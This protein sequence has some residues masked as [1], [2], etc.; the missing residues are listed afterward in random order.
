LAGTNITQTF[1]NP[2]TVAIASV[3]NQMTLS[4]T[5]ATGAY[6]PACLVLA[7]SDTV[8][9]TVY[10]AARLC[11]GYE[12]ASFTNEKFA[13]QTAT[14]SGT[15][16]DVITAKNQVV[17]FAGDLVATA[18]TFSLTGGTMS[19][20]M[21]PLFNSTGKIG[22]TSY[23]YAN[24]YFTT[25]D[26]G[27]VEAATAYKMGGTTVINSS[28]NVVGVNTFAQSIIFSSG[29]TYNV[30]STGA[31]PLNVYGNYIE[32]LTELVLGSG[33]SFRGSLI[34]AINN[35]YAV[36]NTSFRVSNIATVNANISGT[37]TAPSG[38]TG[39]S[40]T[41]TVRDSAGTG[42]CTLIFSGGILTGGTC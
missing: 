31:P 35:T 16:Q 25:A 30:G 21:K 38:G 39:V 19:G 2:Q 8:G 10:G 13:I 1:V 7:S 14:G 3:Q 28:R 37:I 26:I 34:P 23:Y 12:T 32:P 27:T 17:T 40:A 6:D 15:Y 5:N 22:D 42:T 41:K 36:G 9:A 20:T 11:A 4:Q 18:G 29:S 24:G 33:V